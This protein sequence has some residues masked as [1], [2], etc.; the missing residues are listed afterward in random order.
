MTLIEWL[1]QFTKGMDIVQPD[2]WI[3]FAHQTDLQDCVRGCT[4]GHSGTVKAREQLR[5]RTAERLL[6]AVHGAT[7]AKVVMPVEA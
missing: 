6:M 5:R 2:W 1:E 4:D 7:V 3:T